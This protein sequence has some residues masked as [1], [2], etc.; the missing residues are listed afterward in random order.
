MFASI[1]RL[2]TFA[3]V[4]GLVSFAAPRDTAAQAAD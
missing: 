3:S 4:I 1:Q 2:A